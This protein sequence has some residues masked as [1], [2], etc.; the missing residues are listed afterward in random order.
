M[1]SI[2]ERA[3]NAHI[4]WP[5]KACLYKRSHHSLHTVYFGMAAIETHGLHMIVCA[6]LFGLSI[7]NACFLHFEDA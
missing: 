2:M 3:K 7:F 1:H 5:T 4:R 6:S